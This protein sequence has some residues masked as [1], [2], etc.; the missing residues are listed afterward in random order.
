MTSSREA[1]SSAH[2]IQNGQGLVSSSHPAFS[3]RVPSDGSVRRACHEPNVAVGFL[4]HRVAVVLKHHLLPIELLD[5]ML[6]AVSCSRRW[7][8]AFHA[9]CHIELVEDYRVVGRG[10]G[11]FR[12]DTQFYGPE[13]GV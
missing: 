13:A 11:G 6:V 8:H 7:A 4:R 5:G 1:F 9:S 10:Q 3:R 12:E 2:P